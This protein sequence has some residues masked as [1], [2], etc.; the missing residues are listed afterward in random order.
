[1]VVDEAALAA[2][3]AA[4]L[5]ADRLRGARGAR[6]VRNVFEVEPQAAAIVAAVEQRAALLPTAHIHT[7]V[8]ADF[9]DDYKAVLRE[10]GWRTGGRRMLTRSVGAAG[11]GPAAGHAHSRPWG[12][13]TN[14][15]VT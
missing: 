13:S 7:M 10:Q 2:H 15:Q 4:T 8:N 6:C 1:M 5:A 14:A 3:V 11:G 12:Q 9:T